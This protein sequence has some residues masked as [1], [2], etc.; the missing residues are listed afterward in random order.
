MSRPSDAEGGKKT[1]DPGAAERFQVRAA[2]AK[3]LLMGFLA[4][5]VVATPVAFWIRAEAERH[6]LDNAVILTQRVA[7]LAIK[8]LVNEALLAGEDSALS[9]VDRALR[10][11]YGDASVLR[12][13]VWDADGRVVYSDV[14]SLVGQQFDL[15]EW[16]RD[17]LAGGPGTASL[18]SQQERENEYESDSGDLVEVY[19]SSAAFDGTRLIFEAY[20]DDA[21]VRDEQNAVL[22]SMIPPLLLSLAALQLAQLPPALRL[23]RGIQEHQ[24]VRNRLLKRAIE[25]SDLERRRI[26]RDL[27]DDVIQ[28][29]SGL[30]YALESEELHG[31]LDQQ[32][33]FGKARRILQQSVRALRAM[34]SELYPP[35]LD[36]L[37]LKKSLERLV[38]PHQERGLTVHLLVPEDGPLDRGS[39]AL[40]Y[41]VA[42]EALSNSA[43]H[44]GAT[45]VVLS[46]QTDHQGSEI[47]IADNGRGFDKAQGP[48]EGH[49][50]LRILKDTIRE[51]GGALEIL[52]VPGTGTTV[53]AR[54][55]SRL[56]AAR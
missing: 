9:A 53:T 21:P 32:P 17:L 48:V 24:V 2:V 29:L 22:Y 3:F 15:P 38:E 10:P 26:A 27:H 18:E 13:K 6:A 45:T 14:R 36:Q 44:S 20:Y 23:A 8:P 46:L 41:R 39:S 43:K 11:W 30:G 55:S 51:A 54:L 19:V 35:D 37:G 16:G 56:A 47:S 50:G 42:R 5:L 40:L 52:S 12:I 33:V 31:P 7:D 34:T 25:A 28:D 4:L 1:T 49:L